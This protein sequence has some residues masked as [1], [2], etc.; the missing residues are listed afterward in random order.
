MD[1]REIQKLKNILSQ[2]LQRKG[3]NVDK[4]I[5]FGSTL[6][7]IFDKES[8]IDLMIISD[9]F[10]NKDIFERVE[11]TN[12]IHRELVRNIGRPLDIMYYSDIEWENSNSPI[13]NTGKLEGQIL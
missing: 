2:L 1:K 10:R 7:G 3:I 9:D 12:G 11:M 8:D 5:L 6:K 13:I 4:I